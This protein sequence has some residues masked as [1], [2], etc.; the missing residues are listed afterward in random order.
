MMTEEEKHLLEHFLFKYREKELLEKEWNESIGTEKFRLLYD[1]I[2][3]RRITLLEFLDYIKK[4]KDTDI[5]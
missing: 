5:I 1:W 2:R 4:I 3:D